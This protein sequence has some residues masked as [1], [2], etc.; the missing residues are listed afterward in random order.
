MSDRMG[1]RMEWT[2]TYLYHSRKKRSMRFGPTTYG[3]AASRSTSEAAKVRRY[4]R[5]LFFFFW[6]TPY[7][8]VWAAEATVNTSGACQFNT[9]HEVL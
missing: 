5:R 2:T 7:R 8:A 9:A 1:W 3:T 6:S 4:R